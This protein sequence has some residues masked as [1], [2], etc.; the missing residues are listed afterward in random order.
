MKIV[1]I[2][3][4]HWHLDLYLLPLLDHPEAELVGIA[5]PDPGV[6]ARLV[7]RLGCAG[8]TDF[9]ALCRRL[10]PDFVFA[11]GR[12]VDMPEEAR[13]LI[14]EGIPFALEKPCGLSAADVAP[15]AELAAR[16]GAFAA[17]PLVFRNGDFAQHLESLKQEGDVSYASFR[18]IAGFPARYRQ[19]GCDWMLDPSLSGGGCT[20]NLAI[21]FFDLA[22]RLLGPEVRVLN[23]TMANHAWRER[24]EDYSVVTFERAGAL[25]VVET[26]YLYPAPTSNFDMHYALRSPRSYTIAHDM[27]TVESLANDGTSRQWPSV[28]TN[29]PHYRTFVNDVLERVRTGKPPLANLSDMVPIMR[30]VDDAYAKAAASPLLPATPI[31]AS[32]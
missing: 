4:S 29:V 19:A 22:L 8:D 3:A 28:T 12:H 30:L 13:F 7:E 5:D 1:F 32:A 24:V 27:Q 16:K 11:L 20:I 10:R 6:V 15:M 26:G 2:G 18:F 21:H 25:C 14:D 17:V 23:A 31:L 9:R